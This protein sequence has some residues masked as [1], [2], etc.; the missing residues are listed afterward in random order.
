MSTRHPII[1]VTGSSGAGTTLVRHAFADIFRR[2]SI[3]AFFIEGNSFRRWD[4]ETMR[5]EV[6][7]ATERGRPISHFGP[8]ANLFDRLEGVFREYSRT[9][10]ALTRK[11]VENEEQAEEFGVPA[12]TF[13]PWQ[14]M[15]DGVDLLFYEGL[16]GGCTQDTWSHR[17][18]VDREDLPPPLVRVRQQKIERDDYGVDIAQW[19]DLLIGVVPAIYLEWIQKIHRDC[20]KKGCS[21]EAVSHTILRRMPDFVRYIT[22]QFALTDINF[23]RVP[24]VDTSDPFSI[25][26]IPE[27]EESM[28]VIRFREPSRHDF[29]ALL[30]RI[31]GAFMSRPNTLVVPGGTMLLAMELICTPLVCR[32]LEGRCRFEID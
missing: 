29:P 25:S 4:R 9:G 23:Q 28:V 24:L 1:A 15:P 13:T 26:E 32:L 14:E 27:Q 17:Q 22:P 7:A 19:I 31:D 5:R 2:Q 11:Y 3:S 8:D 21:I 20:S 18:L 12:G 10:S 6:Q 16:H 30:D